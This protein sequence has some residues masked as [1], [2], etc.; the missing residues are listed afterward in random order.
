MAEK[1]CNLEKVGSGGGS[2]T[3]TKVVLFDTPTN[4][5]SGTILLSDD[6]T[7]YDEVEFIFA[8]YEPSTQPIGYCHFAECLVTKELISIAVAN[9]SSSG[10][11]GLFDVA[12]QYSVDFYIN[13]GLKIPTTSSL[14]ISQK[15]VK[16]WNANSCYLYKINGYKY[17]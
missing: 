11:G 9:Y 6:I 12:G 7:K 13:Y 5:T 16:G 10:Y 14:A 4:A 1:I 15:I 2:S 3:K 8:Y 17:S